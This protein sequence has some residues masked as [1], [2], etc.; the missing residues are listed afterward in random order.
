MVVFKTRRN[1]RRAG[2][3]VET[4]TW[5][6]WSRN[7]RTPGYWVENPYL[8]NMGQESQDNGLLVKTRTSR[9]W[10]RNLRITGHRVETRTSEYGAGTSGYR[11]TGRDPYL[12]NMKQEPQDSGSPGRDPNLANME[13]EPQ[14]TGLSDRDS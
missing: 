7:L 6:I 8:A 9:I 2:Y 3:R 12:A 10:S 1:L 4:R 11:V 14:D 13:Q 5:R